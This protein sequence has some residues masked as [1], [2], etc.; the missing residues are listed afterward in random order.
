M[1]F[2]VQSWRG[3]GAH[4]LTWSTRI[5]KA[6]QKCVKSD[7]M[8]DLYRFRRP[9]KFL[10]EQPH[11][12]THITQQNNV[13]PDRHVPMPQTQVQQVTSTSNYKSNFDIIFIFQILFS[14]FSSVI[15]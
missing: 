4:K 9:D 3:E 8:M 5:L 7:D 11:P 10:S 1:F 12:Q 2:L 14:F 13:A 15:F 6:V